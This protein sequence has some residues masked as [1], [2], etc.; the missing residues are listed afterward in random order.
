MP[1]IGGVYV[2]GLDTISSWK[3]ADKKAS[4]SKPI[5]AP[6]V[7]K[8]TPTYVANNVTS[9]SNV[10][11]QS[12]SP[13]NYDAVEQIASSWNDYASQFNSAEAQKNRDWQERMS[14]TAHQREVEDLKA[15]GLN[16]VLSAGGSGA[17]TGSG[18]QA[19][20]ENASTGLLN[21][22]A[23]AL[24]SENSLKSAQIMA[25]AN[26]A[27]ASMSSSA[28]RYSAELLAEANKYNGTITAGSGLVSSLLP[29]IIRK[30]IF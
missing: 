20:Y 30:L 28:N 19:S 8:P 3:E 4:S 18:S 27:S 12:S 13:Y 5:Q 22:M 21:F 24:A 26:I 2:P 16:P 1:T 9:A 29:L 6:E 25:N 15:A 10:A 23:Q 14:N 7:V 17:Y 11:S